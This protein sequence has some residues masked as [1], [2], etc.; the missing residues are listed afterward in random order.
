MRDGPTSIELAA[1]VLPGADL[2]AAVVVQGEFH[3]VVV[4]RGE[5]VVK[6]ARG[7]AAGHLERRARLHAALADVGLPFEVPQPLTPVRTYGDRAAVALSWVDG[8]PAPPGHGDAGELRRLLGALASVDLAPLAGLLD[9]PFAYAG[10][11]RWQQVMVDEVVPRMPEHVRDDAARRVAAALALPPVPPSLV[12]G[13]L[14]GDNVLWRDGRVVGVLDWD[15]A[16]P[17]DPAVDAACLA[18]FG[19]DAVR[20]A[21]DEATYDRACTWFGTFPLEHVAAALTA[22]MPEAVVEARV[23]RAATLMR[24]L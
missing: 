20:A 15:L 16:Q 23:A 24:S 13:D 19:W 22:G 2:S 10:R 9:V 18:W 14:A 17:F 6:V 3:D 1:R 21:V 12:H 11:E 5:A 8:D 4:M 7:D